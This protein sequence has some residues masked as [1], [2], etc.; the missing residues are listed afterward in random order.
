MLTLCRRHLK[1][2]TS[3]LATFTSLHLHYV[4]WATTRKHTFAA[5]FPSQLEAS[6]G[7][8]DIEEPRIRFVLMDA[9]CS[10]EQLDYFESEADIP[11]LAR[12]RTDGCY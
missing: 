11:K 9:S 5:V 2:C 8:V 4:W 3:P 1:G 12:V 10:W 7:A 6:I